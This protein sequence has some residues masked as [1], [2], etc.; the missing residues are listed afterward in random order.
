MSFFGPFIPPKTITFHLHRQCQTRDPCLQRE[1]SMHDLYEAG[2]EIS[3]NCISYSCIYSVFV[4]VRYRFKI[5]TNIRL[6]CKC[7]R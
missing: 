6:E 7:K 5:L 1:P 3:A 2:K 4:T